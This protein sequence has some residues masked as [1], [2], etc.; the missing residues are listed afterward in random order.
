M[1]KRA[2]LKA[3][4]WAGYR[5]SRIDEEEAFPT[6]LSADDRSII[7][8]VRQAGL[9]MVSRERL[10]TTAMA[11]HHVCSR[12]ILGA[13][14]EVGVWRGG[15]SI[16][17]ADVFRRR[18]ATREV[19]LYDT[20]AGMTQPSG[21]DVDFAGRR[22]KDEFERQQREQ[23][24]EWCF[25]SIEDVRGN[26]GRLG[27]LSEAVRFVKGDVLQTL[28]QEEQL[29]SAISVLRLDTDWYESTRHELEVLYPR[30]S[31]GGV[32]ILDDYG[33]WGGARKAVDEYFSVHPRP[34]LQYTDYS[35]RAG[36]KP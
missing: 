31:P 6:E 22:A 12:G 34:F 19:W 8:H 23:H 1:V 14:V 21:D 36:I 4:A 15:N 29:P 24:N 27:L 3:A 28:H 9:S 26:F 17:A 5:L 2:I 30:L 10:F 32:L 11:C 25:A 16:V 13:F 35:G 7:D 20:Y 33:H 18:A